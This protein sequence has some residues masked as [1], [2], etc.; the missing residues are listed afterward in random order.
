MKYSPNISLN[1]ET[2]RNAG[3][4]AKW[5]KTRQGAPCMI[6]RYPLADLKHQRDTW[7]IVS[8]SM[9]KDAQK[10]GVVESFINHTLLG[11]YFSI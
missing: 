1:V 10:I 6:A 2:F 9:W 8:Q 5:T 4:E 3:L 11:N 7:W